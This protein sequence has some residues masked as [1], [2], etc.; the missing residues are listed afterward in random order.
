[1]PLPLKQNETSVTLRCFIDHSVLE[2]FGTDGRSAIT[3]RTYPL[4]SSAD[5]ALWS[6][7]FDA[8]LVSLQVW[9]IDTIWL[10]DA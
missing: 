4:D 6:E 3:A 2:A 7:G 9:E 10:E 8:T 1:M 5:V